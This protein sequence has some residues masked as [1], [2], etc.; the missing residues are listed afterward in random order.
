MN[1]DE[2]RKLNF[3][4][5]PLPDD[6]LMEIGRVSSLWASLESLLNLCIGKLVG[7]NDM[8]DPKAFILI[9][10]SSFPQRVDILSTLCEQSHHQNKQLSAYKE[11]VS[12][13]KSAQKMRNKYAHNGMSPNPESGKIEMAVGSARGKL[14]VGVEA[15]DISDI[16]RASIEISE[17]NDALL[18]LVVGVDYGPAWKRV[19]SKQKS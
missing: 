14:K 16:R 10:H 12:R 9:N 2:I 1:N 15:V 17:A 11:I 6:Y 13:L 18:K 8:Y 3:E 4:N 19:N 7:F 5:W